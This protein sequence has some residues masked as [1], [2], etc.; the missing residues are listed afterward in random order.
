M[1]PKSELGS[2][3]AINWRGRVLNP[4]PG[5]LPREVLNAITTLHF[6]DVFCERPSAK[7]VG[8]DPDR[9]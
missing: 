5:L 7:C 6:T 4:L 3:R 8:D 1:A 9:G 2:L